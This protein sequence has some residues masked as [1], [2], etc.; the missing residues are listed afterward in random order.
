MEPEALLAGIRN[1]SVYTASQWREYLACID[2]A[3]APD[4]ATALPEGC[5]ELEARI[6]K[7]SGAS[8]ELRSHPSPAKV[9]PLD[10][11][12][13]RPARRSRLAVA[14]GCF[15]LLHLGHLEL[16]RAA[17]QTVERAGGGELAVLVLG[18]ADVRKKKGAGRPVLRLDERL[19]LLAAVRFVD[20]AV[21]LEDPDCLGALRR[22]EPEYFVK[23]RADVSQRI[24]RQELE[25]ARQ[26]GCDVVLRPLCGSW[27]LSTTDLI[28][29]VRARASAR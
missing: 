27:R 15:D 17:K 1:L 23:E 2:P 22:L 24:V 10:A 11:L 16:L 29:A 28:E 14:S 6:L 26:L 12:A 21:P 20:Y 18:D 5:G 25:L 4:S 3:A 7:G 8:S 19:A 13:G 9:V